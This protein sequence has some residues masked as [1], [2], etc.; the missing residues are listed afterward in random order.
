MHDQSPAPVICLDGPS[1]A[2]KGTVGRMLAQRLGWHFLDSGALYR[3]VAVAA[4]K[5][6]VDLDAA[7]TLA[8]L[9][10]RLDCAFGWDSRGREQIF[11]EGREVTAEVR[12]ETTGAAASKVARQPA[13]RDAL[14]ARQR[15]DRR[16]PGLVADGRDMGTV[17]FP[18]APLKIFLTASAEE[19]ACR[20]HKQLMEH[21]ISASITSLIQE[22]EDRDRQDRDR[23]VSPLVPDA[24][25][26]V[27]DSTGRSPEQ[28]CEHIIGLARIR[29]L[30]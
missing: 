17:V 21:G 8:G 14:L 20:R 4:K 9:A 11:L 22:I 13:V 24:E 26:Q 28:L 7:E 3:L 2:G 27:V 19:R 6:G 5:Q 1:G 23:P 30:V 10:H 29:N 16:S 12:A 15:A 25:A 18:D